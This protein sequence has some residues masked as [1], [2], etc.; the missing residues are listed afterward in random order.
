MYS[1]ISASGTQWRR[2]QPLQP[3]V[4]RQVG[5][6]AVVELDHRVGVDHLVVDLLVLAE[7]LVGEVQVVELDALETGDLA[8]SGLLVD[9]HRVDQTIEI[10]VLDV[11]RLLDGVAAIAEDLHHLGFVGGWVELGFHGVRLGHDQAQRKRR[12]KNLN[13]EGFHRL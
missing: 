12:G 1:G 3:I 11:E 8:R 2:L 13:E 7:L 4:V 10:D 9:H 5:R 6:G